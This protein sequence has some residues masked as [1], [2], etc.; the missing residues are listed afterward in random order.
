[1]SLP[2]PLPGPDTPAASLALSDTAALE[3]A[4][5]TL[6]FVDDEINILNALRRLF[7]PH[8]YRI[9]IAD[10]GAKGLEIL[11]QESVDLVISD[12]RMPVM[13]GARFLA[14]VK[15]RSPGS[16]RILLTG[17]ADMESTIAAINQGEIYRYI[18]KPW[19]DEEV[20]AL[21]AGALEIKRLERDKLRLEA[22]TK[23]QND[24]LNALNATLEQ[25]VLERTSALQ[26]TMLA[27]NLTSDK[28]KKNF[29]T[30]IKVFSNLMELREG[31]VA[32]RARRVADHAFKV[33]R[34][35][36]LS[37]VEAQECMIAGLLHE[38]GKFGL[39]DHLLHKAFSQLNSEERVLVMKH[40]IKGQ[41][42]LMAL[43]QL[44]GA[45]KLIRHQHERYDGMGYPDGL[46]G[47]NIPQGARILAVAVDYE[48]LLCGQLGGQ[49]MRPEQARAFLLEARD[50]RYD[51]AVVEQFVK[52]V[53]GDA[54]TEVVAETV[55]QTQ[56]LKAGMILS[57]DIINR[58]GVLLLSKDHL[59][60]ERVIQQLRSFDQ[61]DSGN[62]SIWVKS[63]QA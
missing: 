33:A 35:M 38:I 44:S 14:Q 62:L 25:R 56:Q 59:L 34:Q 51:P 18:T 41:T 13:D 37:D 43:E 49:V 55:M 9:L 42:A 12:M 60:D 50:K 63:A 24:E 36:K 53:S 15:V 52:L 4:P 21:V 16:V 19:E 1:M 40:P 17:Y 30:S 26:K 22:L 39:P 23:R 47:L 29:I 7:R 10:S 27:L 45:A 54:L 46:S 3:G 2:A 8:G 58:D 57:R 11:A 48:A 31:M 6:L 5:L 20:V 28:L 32:G 61:A